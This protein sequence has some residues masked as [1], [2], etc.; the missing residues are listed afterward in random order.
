MSFLAPGPMDWHKLPDADSGASA[1]AQ[2]LYRRFSTLDTFLTCAYWYHTRRGYWCVCSESITYVLTIGFTILY[3]HLLL[4]Y[5]DWV[6]LI[7]CQDASECTIFRFTGD[8]L[9][10]TGWVVV[11]SFLSMCVCFWLWNVAHCALTI[12][13]FSAIRRIVHIVHR[14]DLATAPDWNDACELV[15]SVVEA[16]RV[17]GL[18]RRLT[19]SEINLRITRYDAFMSALVNHSMLECPHTPVRFR[20]CHMTKTLEWSL[21]R[22][23][24][25]E[26]IKPDGALNLLFVNAPRRLSRRF[27]LLGCIMAIVSPFLCAFIAIYYFFKYA[28]HVYK[29]PV[30][31]ATRR[32]SPY[33]RWRMRSHAELPHVLSRRAILAYRHVDLFIGKYPQHLPCIWG[34]FASF[35]LGSVVGT[36]LVMGMLSERALLFRIGDHDLLWI[37]AVFSATILVVR[38]S[39]EIPRASQE[40]DDVSVA[41]L[42]AHMVHIPL[43]WDGGSSEQVAIDL[44]MLCPQVALFFAREL[45]GILSTPIYLCFAIAYRATDIVEFIER[46]STTIENVGVVCKAGVEPC[47]TWSSTTL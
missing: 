38:S 35:V 17:P 29:N 34:R 37:L 41:T 10:A 13:R 14:R 39:T 43:E 8:V 2:R 11:G 3:A 7:H 12:R 31:M 45:L 6:Q 28:E 16:L 4:L 46:Q 30:Y 22:C 27:R 26:M 20:Q 32:W 21:Y 15:A 25:S 18:S 5:V 19:A 40:A 36:I 44:Q 33:A 1:D 42:R 47:H 23:V 9:T 24:F